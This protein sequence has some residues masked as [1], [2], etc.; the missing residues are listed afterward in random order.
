MPAIFSCV[1]QLEQIHELNRLFLAFLRRRAE[2]GRDCLGMSDSVVGV[3]RSTDRALLD[4]VAEFPRA[5]FD[6]TL[7]RAPAD[8]VMDPADSVAE[9]SRHALNLTILLSAWNVSR[10]SAYYARLLLGLRSSAVHRLRTTSL[11]ELPGLALAP[12]VVRCAFARSE[13]LWREL[14][15]ADRPEVRQRLG[16][17]ALQPWL[18]R[19]WPATGRVDLYPA[20]AAAGRTAG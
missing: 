8:R 1:D 7:S 3:L 4:T 10:H 16:L 18:E 2:E 12:D 9:R 20:R 15:R 13:Q 14:L 11:S 5:L 17:I 6:L 19:D